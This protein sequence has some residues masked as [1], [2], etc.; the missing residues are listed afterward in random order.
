MIL[1][2]CAM[3]LA[4]RT[5]SAQ[6]PEPPAQPVA[7]HARKIDAWPFFTIHAGLSVSPPASVTYYDGQNHREKLAT[8]VGGRLGLGLRVR[9]LLLGLELELLG[10]ESILLEG[11]L[12]IGGLIPLT[13][14][15]GLY[16]CGTLGSN[17]W[18]TQDDRIRL[19]A[20]ETLYGFQAGLA[21]GVR[22]RCSEYFGA[23]FEFAG[24]MSG[25]SNEFG[26]IKQDHGLGWS[27]Y[28]VQLIAGTTFGL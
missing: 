7:S 23:F 18:F 6:E 21:V 28:R 15:W 14:E 13:E 10:S 16:G 22:W 4:A 9:Y 2:L 5:V 25:F 8:Q 26:D 27:V 17:F 12:R 20:P 11:R 1:T 24:N 19:H 3:G